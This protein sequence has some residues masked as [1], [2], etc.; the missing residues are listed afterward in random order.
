[1]PRCREC[2]HNEA[3]YLFCGLPYCYGCLCDY[4]KTEAMEDAIECW[5]EKHT[6]EIKE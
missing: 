5:L 1:M 2:G 6:R 3:Y 4:I